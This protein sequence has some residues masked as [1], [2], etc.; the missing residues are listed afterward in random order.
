MHA[1][2][3]GKVTEEDQRID[4]DRAAARSRLD[5]IIKSCDDED[6][7][8]PPVDSRIYA[9]WA[10]VNEFCGEPLGNGYILDV[11]HGVS[12]A[13]FGLCSYLGTEKWPMMIEAQ[14]R[15]LERYGQYTNST[16]VWIEHP[17]LREFERLASDKFGGH[18]LMFPKV[19][20]ATL[21]W[22]TTLAGPDSLIV[23]DRQAHAS[24][25]TAVKTSNASRV[26]VP[27]NDVEATVE[28][29][30]C[31]D[32]AGVRNIWFCADGVHSMDGTLLSSEFAQAVLDASPH[33]RLYVDD[34][35]GTG[36]TGKG[37][38]GAFLEQFSLTERVVVAMSLCKA[39]GAGGGGLL[40]GRKEDYEIVR[41]AGLVGHVTAPVSPPIL[42][43]NI[44]F[45][46]IVD[47]PFVTEK[48]EHFKQMIRRFNERMQ[49]H[50]DIP[51]GNYNVLPIKNIH[52]GDTQ[53]A[54][55]L[56]QK[57]RADGYYICACCFPIVPRGHA[58]LRVTFN[59]S[60]PLE[61]VDGLCDSLIRHCV[62]LPQPGQR[63]HDPA[64]DIALADE[65]HP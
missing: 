49:E 12:L 40:F 30:R 19:H 44:A 20:T 3:P 35:H 11:D 23:L 43:A 10:R 32:A 14:K 7:R 61:A 4:P 37:G 16:R 5:K 52:V 25:Q 15:A 39:V 65:V 34:A 33:V 50:P 56:V 63:V 28:A 62:G 2:S 45:F 8:Q 27:H 58:A 17:L 1:I 46:S 6:A 21:T 41:T 51:V 60:L 38:R 9:V 48:Q 26:Y 55:E 57:V 24:I 22:A 53:R 13:D 54:I 47:E 42:A 36:W 59:A 31:A 18:F 29:V 64:F